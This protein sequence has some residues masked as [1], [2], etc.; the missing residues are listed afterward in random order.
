MDE[1]TTF[2][3]RAAS[4]LNGRPITKVVEDGESMILTPNHFLICNLGGAVSTIR[5]NDPVKRWHQVK[6]LLDKFWKIFLSENL[7]KLEKARK[8]RR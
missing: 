6:H 4:M 5:V 8:G 1:F 2:V 7:I 3:V